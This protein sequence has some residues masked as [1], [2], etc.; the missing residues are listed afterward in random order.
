MSTLR[1]LEFYSGIGGMHFAAEEAGWDYK[2]IKAFDINTT[3]N[4][5][6]AFNHGK[7]VI[8]QRNIEALPLEFYDAQKADVWTMSPP[9]QPHTR[10]GLKLDS[11]DPRSKSFLYLMNML[12]NM[13]HPPKYILVEN[14]KGFDE[15]DSRDVLIQ[16]LEECEYTYQ[17][18]LLNPLQMGIPNS[19]LRYYL[20]AKAKPLAFAMEPTGS[21]IGY[22]PSSKT[23]TTEFK[24]ERGVIIKDEETIL[25]SE[26]VARRHIHEFLS[27]DEDLHQYNVP[28]K[29]LL[30]HGHAFD[31]VKPSASRSCC[32]TKGY[33]HYVEATGSI[34]QVNED[35][36]TDDT[37]SQLQRW[38]DSARETGTS[39]DEQDQ[40]KVLTCLHH[41]QLRYFSPREV[42]NL[43][44]FPT[45]FGFPE[46]MSLKQKYRT[47]G[48]SI[49]V[50]VVA[51]L[52]KYLV[53]EGSSMEPAAKMRKLE[54][55]SQ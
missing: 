6:Y 21:I 34:L 24:D 15:S 29:V 54:H 11:K 52:M 17:E 48:N 49:N 40:Q 44:G 35:G 37:F 16:Q 38:K 28:D 53:K 41:L 45:S 5:V 46:T 33:Y 47:L 1:V 3:A 9:C 36:D 30:K 25:K 31:I 32:F 39:A 12:P 26:K 55:S 22:V 18:F 8:A 10:T 51:E 23:L 27:H 4:E 43:M 7:S 19:R 42:G 50:L 20:L 14:V 13:K 2:I